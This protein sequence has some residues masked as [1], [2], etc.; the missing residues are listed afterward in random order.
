MQLKFAQGCVGQAC[1]SGKAVRPRSRIP[2]IW[3]GRAVD[4]RVGPA[5]TYVL[6][7]IIKQILRYAQLW[8]IAMNADQQSEKIS[9]IIAKCWDDKTFMQRLMAEPEATLQAEGIDVPDGMSVK[10]HNNTESA[11]HFVIPSR[12]TKLSDLQL[13]SVTGGV[14]LVSAYLVCN[15]A[16]TLGMLA[17]ALVTSGSEKSSS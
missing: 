1:A 3:I 6:A 5:I 17:L 7:T 2:L 12:P 9:Q 15:G 10:V 16:L 14:D 11:M 13:D 4:R 8:R